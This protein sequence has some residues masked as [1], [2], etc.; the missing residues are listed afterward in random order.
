MQQLK[1][2]DDP[3]N[4][5][6]FVGEPNS[7]NILGIQLNE[8]DPT[9]PTKLYEYLFLSDNS[10]PEKDNNDGIILDYN[11]EM[12]EID[13][14]KYFIKHTTEVHRGKII[15][16]LNIS[17]NAQKLKE[18]FVTDY[19]VLHYFNQDIDTMKNYDITKEEN[20][21]VIIN[22]PQRTF[23][24]T[25]LETFNDDDAIIRQFLVDFPRQDIYL[26]GCRVKTID[27]L[28]MGLSRYNRMVY[29]GNPV[30]ILNKGTPRNMIINWR[31]YISLF[32]LTLVLTCQSSFFHSFTHLHNKM[33]KMK[34]VLEQNK[35]NLISVVNIYVTDYSERQKIN[36]NVTCESFS[37]SLSATYKIINILDETI[38]FRVKTE[39]L[40]DLDS[41]TCIIVYETS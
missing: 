11:N 35:Q 14:S 32:M 13:Y 40:F 3:Q 2:I 22:L 34:N 33:S 28:F 19:D 15:N 16:L 27:D 29:F 9:L 7:E 21:N 18:K 37:C 24:E 8:F 10:D 39:T 1:K 4:N 38:L 20:L 26:N 30:P 36:L 41:D 31:Y 23:L 17:P 12:K 6:S 25:L 5:N